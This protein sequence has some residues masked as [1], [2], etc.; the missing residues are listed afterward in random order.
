MKKPKRSRHLFRLGIL[1]LTA[2]SE[3]AEAEPDKTPE[4][5]SDG[6][7]ILTYQAGFQESP[8]KEAPWFGRSGFIHP[9]FSPSGVVVTDDFPIGHRH[10]HGIMFAWTNAIIDGESVDFWNSH[11]MQGKVEHVETI[12]AD[13]GEFQV[14]L[15]HILLTGKQPKTVIR[16]TWKLK[17]VPHPTL[18]IFDLESVME[19]DEALKIG[20]HHYGGLCV[21]GAAE[22]AE[23]AI[24]LT[25]EGKTRADG[26]HTRP[27]WTA[28]W[29][30]SDGK[31]AGIACLGNP[32]NFRAPQPVRLHPEFPYFGVAPVVLGDFTIEPG[33]PFVSR[34]RFVTFDG[35]ADPV[36]LNKLW[37]VYA[38][39]AR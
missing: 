31:P 20:E 23:N 7:K 32:K 33:K 2:I 26:N 38:K 22:W 34:Y 8:E 17:V 10:Q 6:R 25:S 29:G 1:C 14:K 15:R 24:F 36:V 16:E 39:E 21:R 5:V 18:N 9:V 30:K 28:M 35:E 13:D 3:V 27:T 37:E 19:V 11:K 12:K 4:L